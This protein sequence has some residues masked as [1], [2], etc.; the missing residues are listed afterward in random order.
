VGAA[1]RHGT[2]TRST[3]NSVTRARRLLPGSLGTA[4]SSWVGWGGVGERLFDYLA[5]GAVQATRGLIV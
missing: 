3:T 2:V 1:W 5:I 4:V